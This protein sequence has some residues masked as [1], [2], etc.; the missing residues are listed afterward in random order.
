[1]IQTQSRTD[2]PQ[3]RRYAVSE[4]NQLLSKGLCKRKK[5]LGSCLSEIGIRYPSFQ[6]NIADKSIGLM[7]SEVLSTHSPTRLPVLP[8]PFQVCW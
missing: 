3:D 2:P 8:S 5:T 1:M 6:P 4:Y 7:F